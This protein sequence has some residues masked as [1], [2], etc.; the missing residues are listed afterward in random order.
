MSE[1]VACKHCNETGT[2]RNG[3][4]SGSCARCGAYWVSYVKDYKQKEGEP[5]LCSVCWGKGVAEPL[6][7]KWENR[8][9]PILAISFVVLAFLVIFVFG[10][11]SIN[12][13]DKVLVFASTLIGSITGYYFGGER[14]SKSMLPPTLRGNQAADK[15]SLPASKN[16]TTAAGV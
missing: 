7:A 9:T 8:F 14:K 2:C 4:D 6:S 11:W 3:A 16:Q 1:F 15:S 13:F 5:V 10:L 12:Q